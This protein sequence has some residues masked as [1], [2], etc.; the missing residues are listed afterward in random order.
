[1][2]LLLLILLKNYSYYSAVDLNPKAN[3]QWLKL[4][5]RLQTGEVFHRKGASEGNSSCPVVVMSSFGAVQEQGVGVHDVCVVALKKINM[6]HSFF[7]TKKLNKKRTVSDCDVLK[8]HK[9]TIRP[10]SPSLWFHRYWHYASNCTALPPVGR[11]VGCTEDH[12]CGPKCHSTLLSPAS[13]F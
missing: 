9:V 12:S 5:R 11:D 1:M 3:L 2:F 13:P 6:F 8:S 4:N 7:V 10:P